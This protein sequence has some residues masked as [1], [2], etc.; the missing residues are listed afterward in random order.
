MVWSRSNLG[1]LNELNSSKPKSKDEWTVHKSVVLISEKL[2]FRRIAFFKN[3]L[4]WNGL[5]LRT[6]NGNFGNWNFGNLSIGKP[7]IWKI[8]NSETEIS[9]LK[10]RKAGISNNWNHEK[11]RFWKIETWM[12]FRRFI[13]KDSRFS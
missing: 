1:N 4:F 11:L 5:T 3:V 10:F 13:N 2:K 12:N 9:R 7:K 8:E 6:E